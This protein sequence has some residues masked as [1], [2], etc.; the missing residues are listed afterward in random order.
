MSTGALRIRSGVAAAT[1]SISMPPSGENITSGP[2]DAGSF[3]TAA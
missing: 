1:S 3:R 2:F